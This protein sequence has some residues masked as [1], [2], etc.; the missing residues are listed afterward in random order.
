MSYDAAVKLFL[1][2]KINKTAFQNLLIATLAKLC[3]EHELRVEPTGKRLKRLK[4]KSDY[5]DAIITFR[6]KAKTAA[7]PQHTP[8]R[9]SSPMSVDGQ[10]QD[11]EVERPD[12]PMDNDKEV[13]RHIRIRVYAQ[14]KDYDWILEKKITLENNGDVSIQRMQ[15]ELGER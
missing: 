4:K 15:Q 7:R 2:D 5:V 1:S 3:D 11:I 14:E 8:N 13:K 12:D 10:P 6:R 9:D